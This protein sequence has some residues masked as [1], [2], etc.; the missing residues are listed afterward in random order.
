MF[1]LKKFSDCGIFVFLNTLV[2]MAAC[3]PN[4]MCIAQITSK[5]INTLLEAC[6]PLLLNLDNLLACKDRLQFKIDFSSE[7]AK[8]F[9]NHISGS[10]IFKGY[11]D[12]YGAVRWCMKWV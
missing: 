9:A 3:V 5:F 4:I 8:L 7:V 2:Q 1:V 12:T 10:L 6:I 11:N